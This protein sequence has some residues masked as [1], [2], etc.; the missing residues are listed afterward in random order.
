MRTLCIVW[1][2]VM[3]IGGCGGDEKPTPDDD[4]SDTPREVDPNDGDVENQDG[5][6]ESEEE[7]DLPPPHCFDGGLT[8]DET[9]IDCG[10]SCARCE[11]GQACEG[12]S[13]CASLECDPVEKICVSTDCPNECSLAG[14]CFAGVCECQP[15]WTGADCS[16]PTCIDGCSDNGWCD[17]GICKCDEGWKGVDCS[18]PD[19]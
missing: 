4:S 1:V 16:Q 10:G 2:L 15:G 7:E 3:L 6:D 12:R 9:D 19:I 18:Q 17:D 13:D 11:L 14:D 5:D 8:G